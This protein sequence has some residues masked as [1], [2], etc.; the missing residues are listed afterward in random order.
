MGFTLLVMNTAT[1]VVTVLLAALFTFAGSIKL[2]GVTQSL[3]IRDHLGVK[4]LQWR[5]DRRVRTGG[6][7]GR[8]RRAGVV[9]DRTRR[10]DRPG[11][12]VGRRHRVPC[13][14]L[15][16]REGHRTCRDRRSLWPSPP[17]YCTRSD[18]SAVTPAQ[19]GVLDYLIF[20]S[21]LSTKSLT[22]L[23]WQHERTASIP[24]QSGSAP[25]CARRRSR[26]PTSGRSTR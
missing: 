17:P 12:A 2:L 11:V 25:G 1:V 3:A 23:V 26:S 4:P 22:L 16:Q 7:R 9:A 18:V 10:G 21:Q 20:R 6:R 15:R 13:A 19:T 14:R 8:A 5:L 24:A